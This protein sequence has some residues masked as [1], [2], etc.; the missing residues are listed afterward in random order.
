[1]E[2]DY[3]VV[4]LFRG[5]DRSHWT[6]NFAGTSAVGTQAAIEFDCDKVSIEQLLRHVTPANA[7]E[8]KPFEALL[9]V[10]VAIDVPFET[11]LEAVCKAK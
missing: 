9:R 11:Q 3:A 10:K 5:L 4:V 2:V 6:L 1:M 7:D 8:V